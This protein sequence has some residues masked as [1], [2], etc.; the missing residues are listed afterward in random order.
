VIVVALAMEAAGANAT[1]QQVNAKIRDIANAPGEPVYGFEQGAKLL[2][3]GKKI[4]FEGA[5]SRLEFDKYG[6]VSPDFGVYV[7]EQGKLVRRDVVSI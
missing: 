4:N 1:V 5:S 3:A 6:D 2:R 7:V